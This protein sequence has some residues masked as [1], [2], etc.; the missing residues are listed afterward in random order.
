MSR[1]RLLMP[2]N[3]DR[4]L[5]FGEQAGIILR[6]FEALTDSISDSSKQAADSGKSSP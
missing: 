4:F 2:L 1:A 6:T 3:P 5:P